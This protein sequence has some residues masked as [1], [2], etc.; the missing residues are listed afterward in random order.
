MRINEIPPTLRGVKNFLSQLASPAIPTTSTAILLRGN[1]ANWLQMNLQILEEHYR[2]MIAGIRTNLLRPVNIDHQK[3]WLVALHWTVNKYRIDEEV[4]STVMEELIAIGLRI[5]QIPEGSSLKA[6]MDVPTRHSRPKTHQKSKNTTPR[7][8]TPSTSTGSDPQLD[9]DNQPPTTI[10]FD[11]ELN[12]TDQDP[13]PSPRPA[14]Q[15]EPLTK[16]IVLSPPKDTTGRPPFTTNPGPSTDAPPNPPLPTMETITNRNG[17]RTAKPPIYVTTKPP[18]TTIHPQHVMTTA[19]IPPPPDA[20]AEQLPL[21]FRPPNIEDNIPEA[22]LIIVRPPDVNSQLDNLAPTIRTQPPMDLLTPTEM[23]LTQRDGT[24]TPPPLTRKRTRL[25][26]TSP[27]MTDENPPPNRP[28]TARTG[29]AVEPALTR[30]T[31]QTLEPLLP[32]RRRPSPTILFSRHEHQGNKNLNW[33]LT[34]TRPTLILGASNMSR[35]PRIQ[36]RKVQVDC[37]PG[38]RVANAIHLLKHKTPI[39]PQVRLVI[40]HFGLNDSKTDDHVTVGREILELHT[41]ARTTFP[42]ALVRLAMLNIP[43]FLEIR[44]INN[45]N[46]FNGITQGTPH[47]IPPLGDAR[48]LRTI[49][50]IHWT[51]TTARTILSFWREYAAF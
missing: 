32:T 34:P 27:R 15:K 25:E 18:T 8:P 45:A 37:F 29:L 3:A 24:G 36:D 13:P 14:T 5:D 28:D 31:E 26:A 39:S 38:A 9:P 44:E 2:E 49:D 19:P 23:T 46:Y 51:P 6:L 30:P 4:V 40:M 47:S 22:D 11:Q 21:E 17:N 41:T 16:P 42:N 48:L 7:T 1:A 50:G 33:F 20:D 35:L 12:S 10:P 43:P